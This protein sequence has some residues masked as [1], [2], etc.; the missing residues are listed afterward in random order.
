MNYDL[1]YDDYVC[2]E[3]VKNYDDICLGS[4]CLSVGGGHYWEFF[5]RE[6]TENDLNSIFQDIYN[7]WIE[8]PDY[9]TPDWFL[10]NQ[11]KYM[12]VYQ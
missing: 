9:V 8:I 10:N 3:L 5:K 6:L 7:V 11:R 1:T 2:C 12:F 4:I